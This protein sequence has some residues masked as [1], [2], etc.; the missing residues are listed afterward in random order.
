MK[1]GTPYSH[2]IK[3]YEGNTICEQEET[4][5]PI[6]DVKVYHPSGKLKK[7]ISAK[8]LKARAMEDAVYAI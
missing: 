2:R 5:L 7:I 1:T 6:Y 3:R 8:T 4:D